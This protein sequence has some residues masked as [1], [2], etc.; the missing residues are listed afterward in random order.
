[1]VIFLEKRNANRSR[2]V[3]VAVMG[4]RG[5]GG[6][7]GIVSADANRWKKTRGGGFGSQHDH[8]SARR[9]LV[10]TGWDRRSVGGHPEVL[11]TSRVAHAASTRRDGGM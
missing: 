4:G 6:R 7:R 1:M 3:G 9:V 2:R 10:R 5:G 11:K 8:G